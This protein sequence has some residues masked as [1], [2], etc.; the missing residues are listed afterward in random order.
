[1]SK[2][3][4][5][6]WK[7]K[8][9]EEADF[10]PLM[11]NNE[12]QRKYRGRGDYEGFKIGNPGKKPIYLE[13]ETSDYFIKEIDSCFKVLIDNTLGNPYDIVLEL[14]LEFGF[15]CNKKLAEE[16]K[17]AVNTVRETCPT[18]EEKEK[19][20]VYVSKLPELCLPGV[21]AIQIN[22]LTTTYYFEDVYRKCEKTDFDHGTHIL[23]FDTFISK[24]EAAGYELCMRDIET[25]DDVPVHTF[26]EYVKAFNTSSEFS[27]LGIKLDL[28]Q[29]KRTGSGAKTK[30]PKKKKPEETK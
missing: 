18:D 7:K 10:V 22:K 14:E 9:E 26:E 25:T 28:R 27:N 5:L 2:D 4:V 19:A 8:I 21:I 15:V 23:N 11:T 13:S 6:K 20:G 29:V 12:E 24:L 30:A 1:M 17:Y 16:Y 3:E